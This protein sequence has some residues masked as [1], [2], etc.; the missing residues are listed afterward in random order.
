M[1]DSQIMAKIMAQIANVVNDEQF[2]KT[3][4]IDSRFT[5]FHNILS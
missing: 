2:P 1:L 4:K 5:N 3:K